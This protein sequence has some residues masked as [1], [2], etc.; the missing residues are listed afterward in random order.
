MK[1]IL[2]ITLTTLSNLF[3]LGYQGGYERSYE[4][5]G[6]AKGDEIADSLKV[7]IPLLILGFLIAYIFM[8]S[9]NARSKENNSS[10]NIG[11]LGLVIMA[12]GAVF[13]MPLLAWFEFIFVNIMTIGFAI[14]VVG[15]ILYFIYSALTKK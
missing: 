14:V 7:A 8:W 3:C 9:K 2:L 11:C 5:I 12:I 10:T 4:I 6:L 13:L 1:K 15:V